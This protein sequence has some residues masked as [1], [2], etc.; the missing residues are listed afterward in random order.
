MPNDKLHALESALANAQNKY[1]L[2]VALNALLEIIEEGELPARFSSSLQ[3]LFRDK[4]YELVIARGDIVDRLY[5]VLYVVFRDCAPDGRFEKIEQIAQGALFGEGMSDNENLM[6]LELATLAKILGGRGDEGIDFY[7]QRIVLLDIHALEAQKSSQFILQAFKHLQIPFEVIKK[8]LLIVLGEGFSA[9]SYKQKRSVFNWQL[10]VFWNV[11]HYF[12]NK[13]WLDLS[14]AWREIFY[15][16]LAIMDSASMDFALYLHF[17]I[18]HLCGN[19][20]ALQEEWREFNAQITLHAMPIYEKFARDFHLSQP[21]SNQSGVIG[22]LR[23]RLVE[24]SP[25]K[26]EI[27]LLTSLLADEDFKSR[28]KI[29][30]YVMSLL[31]KSDNDKAV[32]K[33]YEDLGIEV[34]D[35]G[36]EC[37][38]AGYYNS[39][40]HKAL[41]LR[42]RI[43][44]DGVE[45]LLSPNNGY[46]ISDF[47][48]STRTCAKQIFWSH[49][50]FVY[51]MPCL[52]LKMTH[53]CGNSEEISH[54][55]Y[56]FK[57]VP[58]KMHTR[59]YNPPIEESII[60]KVRAQ[61]PSESIVLGN[62]GRLVKIDN[63]DFLRALLS[64]MRAHP[65]T[66]FLA[67]G[68][69]NQQEIRAKI[70]ELEIEAS[71]H[72]QAVGA[73][74][75][76]ILERFYF[77]G[78]VDSGIYGHVIDI[79]LDSFPMEQ[80]E[81]RI[82]YAAKGKPSLIL[83]KE[84]RE[85]RS[86]RLKA[87]CEANS[88]EIES[89]ARESGE[90]K[91]EMLEFICHEES[92]VA[93][94]EEDY[95][96]KA[97]A[98]ITMPP[99][100]LQIYM[101][102]QGILKVINDHIRESKGKRLFLEALGAL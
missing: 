54:Q 93:F 33:S 37:N 42:E 98:L 10:H 72:T 44:G 60:K 36:L 43:Q 97:H 70:T 85:Q 78:F 14:P 95:I 57:G 22:I 31:E 101:K 67:C 79:W 9:L 61:Y 55:G 66:I 92:F 11:A 100:R 75:P 69:G 84:S 7:L 38:K 102:L 12:N 45:F 96:T 24:N 76:S 74:A 19:N 41:L 4:I 27:S 83:A 29:K 5:L 6:L 8:N 49:G 39:H 13:Q 32:Q 2:D 35:V 18:Y 91:E 16:E 26:V 94:D 47:L 82:E 68:A 88:A 48:L 40:L 46:G 86:A 63:K 20:F 62:I 25:Y 34:V 71:E 65:K 51:D 28:Y 23:D 99:E 15:R 80:G 89:I 3:G 56:T 58:V 50:N 64:I 81:S 30:L 87:W 17:F 21:A 53:I 52:D 77:T 73:S 59:F 90:S 1:Q